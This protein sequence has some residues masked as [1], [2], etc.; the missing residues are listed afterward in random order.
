MQCSWNYYNLVF[1]SYYSTVATL[2]KINSSFTKNILLSNK[3]AKSCQM[4]QERRL[5]PPVSVVLSTMQ[6]KD[7]CDKR[8][9]HT[10]KPIFCTLLSHIKKPFNPLYLTM[11]A[12]LNPRELIH[13]DS[14]SEIFLKP[15]VATWFSNLP[16]FSI[17]S[18]SCPSP[19]AH[20]CTQQPWNKWVWTHSPL[21]GMCRRLTKEIPTP[22]IPGYEFPPPWERC[23]RVY[24]H[25]KARTLLTPSSALVTSPRES[26]SKAAF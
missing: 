22:N 20:L 2:E 10:S 17:N 19:V 3:R 24:W 9:A 18:V 21:K 15:S 1:F 8:R 25:F 5:Q 6:N 16:S 23:V 4:I 11:P 13:S 26:T 7:Q 12:G 14:V